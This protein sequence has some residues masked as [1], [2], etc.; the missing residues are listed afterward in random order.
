MTAPESAETVFVAGTAIFKIRPGTGASKR[1]M[2]VTITRNDQLEWTYD[3]P[4]WRSL[5]LGCGNGA[6]YLWSARAVIVLPGEGGTDPDVLEVDEDL[7]F[8]F[9]AEASWLLVCETSVRLFV[10]RDEKSRIEMGE[11]IEHARWNK[12][13]L[14]VEDASGTTTPIHIS[15]ERLIC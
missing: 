10:G 7:L 12:G 6:A 15:G 2:S 9:K 14:L 5:A 11:V 8:V 1:T 13:S 3:Q 4:A